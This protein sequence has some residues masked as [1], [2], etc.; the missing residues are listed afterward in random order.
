MR[1][2]GEKVG[3]VTIDASS[4]IV[5]LNET[6]ATI[7]GTTRERML[8]RQVTEI[9]PPEYREA[10]YVAITRRA[11]GGESHIAGLPL[12]LP[13]LKVDGTRIDV[14]IVLAK[15]DTP[16]NMRDARFTATFVEIE[17][18]RKSLWRRFWDWGT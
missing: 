1:D 9:I 12:R 13:M 11:A 14:E 18:P 15:D 10:H 6:A 4:Q 2:D 7:M 17:R 5:D 3:R 16:D 8:G